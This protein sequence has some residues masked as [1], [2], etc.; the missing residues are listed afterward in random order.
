MTI[1]LVT[2]G[3]SPL[4]NELLGILEAVFEEANYPTKNVTYAHISKL[5]DLRTLKSWN[6]SVIV[7]MGAEALTPLC[8]T[9]RPLK[10]Y[11]GCLTYHPV[12]RTWVLP[13]FHPNGIYTGRYADF[14]NVYDHLRRAIELDTGT[15][16]FPPVRG[17]KVDWEFIGH[18]GKR[19][20]QDD[21]KVWSGYFEATEE[22]VERQF[23][24]LNRWL[25]RLE[26]DG[27]QYFGADT[28]SFTT[29]HF[30]PLTMIQIYD[31]VD[32]KA[33]AFN[34]GVV[35]RDRDRWVRF[36][37]HANTRLTWHNVQHDWKMINHWL[38]VPLGLNQ[39][40]DTMC[41]ALGLTEKG[42]QTG[43]KY[44][45]RQYLN[46]PFYEEELDR[47]LDQNNINYGHIRPDVLAE[48]GCADVF[49]THRLAGL[50]PQRCEA[51]GTDALVRNIL[52]P[53]AVAF[54][55]MEY[56]GIRVDTE[57]A[58]R[59]NQEWEPLVEES[60]RKVQ[61]YAAEAGFPHDESYTGNQVVREVC[62]CVPV[63]LR[64][65]LEGIR[66][67]SYGKTLRTLHEFN[68]DCKSCNKRRYVRRVDNTINVR[69]NP[70]M[71]HLCFDILKMEQ[72][73]EGR[74]T[75]KY[76]WEI[77]QSHE[78]AQLVAGYREL[79]YLNRNIVKGFSKFVRED[80]RV[81]P[82]FLLFGTA[83]GRLAVRDPAMQTVPSRSA[84]A[85]YVKRL[86]LPDDGQLL[87]NVDYSNLELYMAHHLT[88][89]ERLLEALE[90]DMHRTTA[91]AMYMKTYEEV[92]AEERQSAKP[93]N[94]GAGYNIKASKLSK[95]KDLINI[96]KGERSKAQEFL[97]AFWGTY[98]TWDVCRKQWIEQAK[99]QTYLQTE[100]G[101][102][103]RWSLI[104]GDNVWK[105]EN[106]ATNFQG[107]SMASDLCLTSLI[108]LQSE[109]TAR[110]WGRVI[111]TVHDSL[112]FSLSPEHIHEAVE[113][114]RHV[115]TTP[116]F[117]TNTPFKVDVEV[118]L[119]YGDTEPYDKE[120]DYEA[121]ALSAS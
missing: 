41:W 61:R 93:V 84:N 18:N 115:M 80:L 98:S 46:A 103:R 86:F 118:G 70:H 38:G 49:Y 42:N 30:K 26:V 31:P 45:A 10:K 50:L 89:D 77:N 117:P 67:T 51:E 79:D 15:M 19:G 63:Q 121:Y 87:V 53:A 96:T 76:F 24:V 74:K 52:L 55:Q 91:A 4:T 35:N 16:E 33:Y 37:T 36:L 97:D 9:D 59:L 27:P 119:N 92:T 32:N 102:K 110:G 90:Q 114:I 43:L 56:E 99:T 73:W 104:T 101:R 3:D 47:W 100:L 58:E 34:W 6:A 68:P 11:A 14:D 65:A 2:Y 39:S 107:Q 95:Q 22:E 54:A 66:V 81:H 75:N 78:F 82:R 106:Q 20:Y 48:Y 120:K 64:G 28:E 72:T 88:G 112:V 12:L 116:V 1:A 105:V 8:R 7:S 40:N 71:H 113:L 21:P 85:K 60:I 62:G 83:T 94:F 23:E 29:D 111:L 17:T 108:Q 25:H 44:L 109:L 57:E 13:T 69:S 5:S